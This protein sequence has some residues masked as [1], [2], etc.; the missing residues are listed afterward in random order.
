[1]SSLFFWRDWVKEYRYTWIATAVIFCFSLV[2]L[3]YGYFRGPD[4]VTNWS[5]LQEQ[6]T[7]ETNVHTFRLGPFEINVPGESYVILEHFNASRLHP[8]IS[9][10]YMFLGVFALC[11]IVLISVVT[12]LEKFWYF[13]GMTLIILLLIS[14][15]FEVLGLFGSHHLATAAGV[16]GLYA[17]PSV[18]FNLFRSRTPLLF[19]IL[20]FTAITILLG[21]AIVY[22]SWVPFP[23]YHIYLT[24]LTGTMVL[25]LIFIILVGHEIMAAFVYLVGQGPSRSMQHMLIIG[26]IYLVNVFIT[27]LHELRVINWDFIYLNA[28]LLLSISALIGIWGYRN[29][30]V[31]YRNIMAFYPF[32]ALIYLALGAI[33][34]A[35]TAHLLTN[36]N[37]PGLKIIREIIIFVHAGYGLMFLLYLISN[38]GDLLTSNAPAYR[39]MYTPR[40]MPYF[41]YRLA[42]LIAT[43]AFVVYANWRD[44]LYHGM[45]AFYN[46][47]GDLHTRMANETFAE[48]FY[49]QGQR[50]GYQNYRSSY[51][52]AHI[53]SSKLNIKEAHYYYGL[54]NDKGA[55][56]YSLVNA[57]NI[58]LWTSEY[59]KAIKAYTDGLKTKPGSA[60]LANNAGVAYLKVRNVDSAAFF[61]NQAREDRKARSTAEMNFF[62]LAA[63]EFIPLKTDSLLRAFDSDA[64]GTISNA[65]AS[66]T[67]FRTPFN[68]DVDP[69]ANKK[70]NLHTATL[71][72]NYT[73]HN[74]KRIDSVFVNEA[75]RIASDPDNASFSEALKSSLAFG[76]YHQ[77]NISGA[78]GVL[79]EQVFLSQSYQ[80]KFNYIMGL[81]ALEQGNPERA[82]TFFSYA[83]TYDFKDARFYNAIALT[84]ARRVRNAINAWDTVLVHG[85]D[86]QKQ[87][88]TRI[89]QILT[90]PPSEAELLTDP[91]RYQF[92]RYRIGTSDSVLFN[93]LS[94]RFD[95]ANYKAQAL[96]DMSRKYFE[97]G[98]VV[99][100]IRY[101]R[102][103][104]GLRL[105][106]QR[107][108]NETRHFE[109]RMLASRGQVRELASQIN[110]GIEFPPERNLEKMFY[111]ALISDANGDTITAEKNY[112]VLATYNPYFEEA[113]I[114]AYQFFRKTEDKKL[115]PYTILAEAIQF[116]PESLPLLRVYRDEAL[117]VGLDEYAAN[118]TERIVELE[119][120]RE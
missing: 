92:C 54:A 113:V 76:F 20:T 59:F 35:T 72:N 1:M 90:I 74:A 69:L 34:F 38:Y 98:Q 14:L 11:F 9:S 112:R 8:D 29:R 44:Y 66:A 39:V 117:R 40:R 102:R 88:A 41:S 18:Y 3:W 103:I 7:L 110:D 55:T 91:E 106:D 4:G 75:Y 80:G 82:S 49:L 105:T 10:S 31:L 47:A 89:K 23:F 96:L 87:I 46:I 53:K 13:F 78:M 52:L 83:D 21:A 94:N 24:S 51:M 50:Q 65:L 97:A 79:A 107:L 16:I 5:R 33:C 99:P 17:I 85:D 109:L 71:L 43:L 48:S 25:S 45:A 22:F 61:L 116:N 27:A 30:E 93:R 101:Y 42:G 6:K 15:R 77:G 108:Y 32:G 114:A 64:P 36:L 84:E 86:A 118:V 70:L 26:V 81:W 100:A 62:G 115:Y 68:Y 63:S 28:Y 73:I 37:D 19:R 2:F 56:E 12:T 58:H 60:F 57:G 95:D 111:T 104:G 119:T 120:R 67:V